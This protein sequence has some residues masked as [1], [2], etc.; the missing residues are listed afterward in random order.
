MAEIFKEPR[1]F[2]FPDTETPLGRVHFG[3]LIRQGLGTGLRGYRQYGMYAVV[4]IQSGEGIYRDARGA[5]IPLVA[6]DVIIVFPELPHHYGPLPGGRWDEIFI[7]FSGAAFNAWR[8]HGLDPAHPVWKV[9]SV[10]AE[11]ARLLRI[12]ESKKETF[13]EMCRVVASLHEL[14]ADWLARRPSTSREPDWLEP[15]RRALAYAQERK[16]TAEIARQCGL[17][18]DA[19]RRA[20]RQHTGE[21]PSEFRR[22]QRLALARDFLRRRDLSLAQIAEVLG[23]FDAFHFSKLFKKRFGISPALF[24]KLPP[25]P[26]G[27]I[28]RPAKA[29]ADPKSGRS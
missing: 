7:A 25:S 22:N 29:D 21:S 9:R 11:T 5:E 26:S 8:A 14:L 24:R 20:F 12:L 2:S 23:F 16:S 27:E 6:G 13:G 18:P 1:L 4:L 17:H 15:A 19:F 10:K 28:I 3:G